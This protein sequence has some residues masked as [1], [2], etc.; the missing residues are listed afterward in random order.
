LRHVA[1][2][3]SKGRL[4]LRRVLVSTLVIGGSLYAVPR[5]HADVIRL[6]YDRVQLSAEITW[7]NPPAT[8]DVVYS[9]SATYDG[10]TAGQT[11]KAT[12]GF[13][14]PPGTFTND[15]IAESYFLN[16][17][18]Q[19]GFGMASW[20]FGDPPCVDADF[21]CAVGRSLVAQSRLDWVFR[22]DGSSTEMTLEMEADNANHDLSGLSLYDLTQRAFVADFS[23]A[24]NP[25]Q[26]ETFNL[27]DGHKY[28]LSGRTRVNHFGGDPIAMIQMSSNATLESSPPVP[29][30]ASLLLLGSGALA[31]M[32]GARVRARK[33][34]SH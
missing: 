23:A 20:G 16:L 29:E 21:D 24:V 4:M 30:P 12:A 33:H 22:V 27:I 26:G 31:L 32:R 15:F 19:N 10:P 3:F 6:L 9:R 28:W 34:G 17:P 25:N 7:T 18:A 1:L 2:S 5:A 13:P 8:G 14:M 11:H